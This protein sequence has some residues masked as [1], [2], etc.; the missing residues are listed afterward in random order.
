MKLYVFYRVF[1]GN[2][3]NRPIFDGTKY[4]LVRLCWQSF[5][6]QRTSDWGGIA[7]LLDNCPYEYVVLMEGI[8]QIR[9][10]WGNK[11]SFQE[12][13]QLALMCVPDDGLILFAEDDYFWLPDA[14]QKMITFF[15]VYDDCFLSPYDHPD[16][17]ERQDNRDIDTKV[18]VAGKHHWRTVE[19]TTMTFACMKPT[20]E[21]HKDI[22]LHH[23]CEG[24][25]MWYPIIDAG[26]KLWGPIPSLATHMVNGL[27]AP[28]IDWQAEFRK[29]M[30]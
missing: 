2:E 17:Y 24:R 25:G 30:T 23:G 29:E 18:V 6:R 12:Q 13:V 15:K 21:R 11:P 19:S 26:T 5:I 28:C 9:A 27:L 10:T 16:R 7:V 8:T 3:S 14:V 20:L 22:I 4:E 1:S